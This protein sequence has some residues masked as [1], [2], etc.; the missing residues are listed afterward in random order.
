MNHGVDAVLCDRPR[1]QCLIA[2]VADQELCFRRHRPVES[3]REIVDHNHT[4]AGVDQ[5]I[6]RLATNVAGAAGD[7]DRHGKSLSPLAT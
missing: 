5:R 3:G 1:H 6:D 4:L 7:Q 2:D